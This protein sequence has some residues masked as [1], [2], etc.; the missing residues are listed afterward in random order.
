MKAV[1]DFKQTFDTSPE[2]MSSVRAKEASN[3]SALS[4][5]NFRVPPIALVTFLAYHMLNCIL[6]FKV[7]WEI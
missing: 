7:I 6:S 5:Q 1:G 2:Q 3:I 4:T